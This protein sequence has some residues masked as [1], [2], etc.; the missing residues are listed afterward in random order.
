[1]NGNGVII[2]HP[3]HDYTL[4]DALALARSIKFGPL[5]KPS[6]PFPE[7]PEAIGIIRKALRVSTFNWIT[8][9]VALEVLRSANGEEVMW[10]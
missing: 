5:M 1:M 4:G 10:S 2:K 3:Y 8:G 9:R 6:D 7:I